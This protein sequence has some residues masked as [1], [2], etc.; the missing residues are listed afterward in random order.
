MNIDA[1]GN[2]LDYKFYSAVMFSHARL[3]YTKVGKILEDHDSELTQQYSGVMDNLNALY[4]L[5]KAL[6]AA[7][8]LKALQ[9]T[10]APHDA[11]NKPNYHA[12]PHL[13]QVLCPLLHSGTHQQLPLP[14]SNLETEAALYRNGIPVDFSEETLA[15][16]KQLPTAVSA[17]DKIG[18]VDI[19][20]M[21]LVTIEHCIIKVTRI[22]TINRN[23][24]H[25]SNI[26]TPYFVLCA[27]CC[28]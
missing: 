3:T 15:Q 10:S 11:G 21:K 20:D 18:R 27:Y 16:T 2:L 23:Q 28:W 14:V 12:A 13:Y 25:I 8:N 1:E 5:Y 26:N 7:R 22:F 4:D 24:F 19:T 6:K 9:V 17:Q